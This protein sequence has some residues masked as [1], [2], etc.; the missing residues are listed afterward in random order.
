MEAVVGAV[1]TTAAVEGA[2]I[3]LVASPARGGIARHVV[4]LLT[5]LPPAGYRVRI[6]CEPDGPIARAAADSGIHRYCLFP[7]ARTGLARV[8]L[9]GVRLA[10]AAADFGAQ[11]IHTHSFGAGFAGALAAPLSPTA[12]LVATIHNYPPAAQGMHPARLHHR[13][14]MGMLLRRASR[15]ITV[16]EALRRD[17]I[18]LSPSAAERTI[19]IPNGVDTQA[20][21]KRS[22]AEIRAEFGLPHDRP[23]V[24]MIARLAPQKGIATFIRAAALLA[25]GHPE[26]VLILAGDGPLRDE[27]HT[28]RREL[29]LENRLH[30]C[31]EVVSPRELIAALDILVVAS[32]SEG[33]S[34]VAMEAMS[35]GKPVV[36]TAVGGVPEVVADGQTGLLVEPEDPEA[37]AAAVRSLL[38]DPERAREFGD[39]GRRRAAQLFDLRLMLERTRAVYADLIRE[40]IPP[41]GE[42]T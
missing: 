14:A 19:T 8:A 28:L 17:L 36:A 7:S 16:S 20:Q 24:G 22:T 29:A 23:V 26:V 2:R 25:D 32:T 27:A 18:E 12:R 41:R 35:A 31:Q 3:L 9:S 5:E 30:L 38:D 1:S 13:W 6:A 21:A 11:I 4:S 34:V 42:R 40:Q 15:L 39:Q 37:L 33:S 10:R